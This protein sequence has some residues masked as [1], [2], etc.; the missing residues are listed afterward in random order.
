MPEQALRGNMRNFIFLIIIVL[1]SSCVMSPDEHY[2]NMFSDIPLETTL[3]YSF[4]HW[5]D[6]ADWIAD[7]INYKKD[8]TDY[9]QTPQETLDLGTGDCEDAALLFCALAFN[10]L[11]L[12]CNIVL[13]NTEERQVVKGGLIDH[14]MVQLPDNTLL[15]PQSH[16]IRS[17]TIRYIYFFDDIFNKE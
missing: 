8:I 4:Y 1:F 5:Y 17:Y 3:V 7:N 15:S 10:S 6:I 14:A 9:A 2:S 13:V 16:S 12:K 11:G